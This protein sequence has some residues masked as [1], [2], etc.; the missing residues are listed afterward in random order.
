M[1]A[2]EF[3]LELDVDHAQLLDRE[4]FLQRDVLL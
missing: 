1:D 4:L 3:V 2:G